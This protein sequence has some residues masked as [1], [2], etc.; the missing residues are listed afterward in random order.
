MKKLVALLFFANVILA[1][2]Q[3]QYKTENNIRYYD[4][5]TNN[6]DV[7]INSQCALDVYFPDNQK[8]FATIIWFHG[9]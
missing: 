3:Q 5:I 1:N 6:Q 8:D 7:Y 4:E 2:A 9:G